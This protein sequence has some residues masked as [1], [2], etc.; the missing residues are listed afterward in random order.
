MYFL[1]Y[2]NLDTIIYIN[3]IRILSL[4]YAG[5]SY[6]YHCEGTRNAYILDARSKYIKNTMIHKGPFL[7]F[8]IHIFT[9]VVV[10]RSCYCPLSSAG[11]VIVRQCATRE[12]FCR[13]HCRSETRGKVYGMI[14]VQR[15]TI[16]H[17]SI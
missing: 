15:Y 4:F 5:R 11:L 14:Y 16:V 1:L 10:L 3:K 6:S 2:N 8:N 17:H 7:Y 13:E 9:R 12:V